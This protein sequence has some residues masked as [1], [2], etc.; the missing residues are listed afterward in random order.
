MKK[1]YILPALILQLFLVCN[2]L[3]AQTVVTVPLYPTDL[4]SCT[5]VF[6]ASKGNAGLLNATPPIYAHTGVILMT[7]NFWKFNFKMP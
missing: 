2:T 4:D 5:I 6:D 7:A 1:H 3:T